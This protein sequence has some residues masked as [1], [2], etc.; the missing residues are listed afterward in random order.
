VLEV[1][2]L[3]DGCG[4]ATKEELFE[5]LNF[6]ARQWDYYLNALLWLGLAVYDREL[7]INK[8][9]G[10]GRE[11]MAMSEKERLLRIGEIAFSNEVF[12][13]FLTHD[14]PNMSG[15]ILRRNGLNPKASTTPRRFNTV[16]GWRRF[17]G[18]VLK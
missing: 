10:L 16:L 4:S 14:R 13:Y 8:L 3:L 1:F 18:H 9:S 5:G 17:L 7:K 12:N 15:D 6:V 11:L 2:Y